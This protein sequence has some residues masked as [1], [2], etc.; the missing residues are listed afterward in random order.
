MALAGTER[1]CELEKE[2]MKFQRGENRTPFLALLPKSWKTCI[3]WDTTSFNRV[4]DDK[5]HGEKKFLRTVP[6][7]SYL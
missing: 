3:T 4:N 5:W 1:K 2:I 7:L 6:W